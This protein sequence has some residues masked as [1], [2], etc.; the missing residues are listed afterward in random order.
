MNITGLS[1]VD[2]IQI[3]AKQAG[4]GFEYRQ[5]KTG[6]ER[7][8][9]YYCPPVDEEARYKVEQDGDKFLIRKKEDQT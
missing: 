6:A 4:W 9:M 3:L 1:L 7:I 5:Y 8:V 2:K